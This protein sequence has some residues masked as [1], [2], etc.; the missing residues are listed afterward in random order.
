MNYNIKSG[1]KWSSFLI[2]GLFIS[3]S[4][5]PLLTAESNNT[6]GFMKGI[7]YKPF[8]PTEQVTFI[9]HDESSLVDD[10]AFLA[11]VPTSVFYD[12]K[13]DV[14]YAH[15]L[16]FYEDEYPV[17]KEKE[18]SLNAYQGIDY[19]MQDWMSYADGELDEI[20]YINTDSSN[21]PS[22]WKAKNEVS[23][24]SDDPF[25]LA[26]DIALM[27]W[28]Y[29]NDAVIAVINEEYTIPD[30][31]TKGMINGSLEPKEIKTEHFE[32]PQTNEV[33]PT[34]N[35]FFVPDGYKFMKVRSWYPCFYFE[36]GLPGFEGLINMSI[37]AGDR[38]IQVYCDQDGEWMMA[39]I[40]SEWNTQ[41]GMDVDKTSVYVYNGGQWS[42]AVTDVPT[43]ASDYIDPMEELTSDMKETSLDGEIEKHRSFLMFNFGRYGSLL[44]V[45]KNLREVT[46]QVDVE[47]YPGVE[48]IIPE[49]P[50]FG[51]RDFHMEL[52]WDDSTI[53]LGMS[54]IGPSGEEV[55][56][57][58][59]PGVSTKCASSIYD[60]EIPLPSGTET[61]LMVHRLG[62][63]LPGEHYKICIFAMSE[64]DIPINY[65][66][67]Y[68]WKQNFSSEE[69]DM[70]SSATQGAV[71][72]SELNAPLLYIKKDKIPSK[73]ADALYKLGIEQV[74]LINIGKHLSDSTRQELKNSFSLKMYNDAIKVYDEIR[75]HSH[76]NDVIFSTI[77]SW[78]SWYV[79]ELKP[80]EEIYGARCIGPA[81]YIAAIHGSPVLF[82]D[83]HPELSSSVAW[84]TELWRRHPD[85]HSRLPTVSEMYLT[86]SRVYQFLKDLGFDEEGQEKIITVAGQFDIGL[87]W[88]RVFVGKAQP[89]RFFGSPTDLS[90]WLSKNMFYPMIVF[91]NPAIKNSG[92][93]S[94]INGSESVRKFPWR[95]NLGLRITK[96]SEEEILE[97]PVLDTLV[98][99]D[100]KFNSRASK[101]WGF[102]YKCADGTIPGRSQTFEPI[103][104]GVMIAVNGEEGS[105][106]ADLSGSEVQ[107]FYL[108][109]GG[110]SPVFSTKFDANM[111]NLNQGVLLW[112][113]NTHGA[114][115]DGG[116]FM[117]WDV[118]QENS[119]GY[120]TITFAPYTKET[121]PW[122]G[123]EW[124]MGSTEEPDTMTMDVHGILPSL[125]GNPDP[126]GTRFLKTGLDWAVARRPIRDII[127]NIASLPILRYFTP[128]WLQDTQDYYDGVII[129]VLLSRFGTSWYNG[130]QVDDSIG[131][132]HSVGVSSVAC[133]PAGKYLHLTLMRHGSTFQIMDPWAT[134]W[135]SDVW[136]N[137]VPRGIALGQT[138]GEIYAE[139]ITKVGIQYVRDGR[140]QWWW[141]LAENVCL[142]G[143]PNL[144]VWVPSTEFSDKNHWTTDEAA[145]YDFDDDQPLSIDGHTPFGAELHTRSRNPPS[146][147]SEYGIVLAASVCI[148]ILVIVAIMINKRSI[149][150]KK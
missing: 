34:Y 113:V 23:I 86:G 144:R 90:V 5:I 141:D 135:Y 107:P 42:V 10:Y 138:I 69:G 93:V 119:Y 89:G 66:I 132:I 105:Y 121:N 2:I 117:F 32:V 22:S 63:C 82:V 114:P 145:A 108:R 13:N 143:D 112:M 150:Q 115:L 94:V 70:L 59:E 1:K 41:S 73:T 99:Y 18:R 137:G 28:E 100:I 55:L 126:I 38:D 17:V 101:Y 124:L 84:H 12:Q 111:Y 85:G 54:L 67:T 57:T 87:P 79:A 6:S 45:L 64:I 96:P 11:S 149:I 125:A 52:T 83:N 65:K 147:L 9:Q 37:P 15:P 51:A 40:T 120:P 8:I 95:G 21:T 25:S 36:A 97:Y 56:S 118:E 123:Y 60:E 48:F 146:I 91:E 139:G 68:S 20:T 128:D 27:E 148:V 53:D 61:D 72:A 116:M 75:S 46:Y 4:F 49:T 98:C 76:S 47:M 50:S 39:G 58:R 44:E 3:A 129:T 29:S 31:Q 110:Y 136:Q 7:S 16:L 109:Q 104:E 88:D 24:Q 81:A 134:S 14:L 35:E 142:Y 102:E 122:R 74:H 43:K 71:L 30:N 92:G 106:F 133:L 78:T 140:P 131:N 80:D 77:D 127:G 130:S 103:D 26:H 62:E 19:F 33:Y